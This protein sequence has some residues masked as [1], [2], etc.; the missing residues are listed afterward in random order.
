MALPAPNLD[1]RRFQDLVDDA[2]RL[3]QQHCPEWTDHNVS[4]P[5]VTLIEL[6][7]W[8]TDQLLYRLNRVPERNYLKFL[9]LIGVK[10]FPPS[11]ARADVTFWLSAPRDEPVVVPTGTQIATA[12]S[13]TDEPISFMT[14]QE[15]DIEPCS[16]AYLSTTAAS[17]DLRRHAGRLEAGER[18]AAFDDPPVEGDALL[19]G[20]LQPVPSCAVVLRFDCE[21]EGVGVDPL[22]PP[23]AWEAW[24]GEGWSECDL[25]RDETGGLNRAGDVVLHVPRTHAASLI[26]DQRAGWLRCR[27]TPGEESQP[28]YTASPQISALTAFTLGGTVTAQNAEPIEGEILGISDGTPGQRFAL[29]RGPVVGGDPLVLEVAEAPEYHENGASGLGSAWSEW[30]PTDTFARG[31]AD[32]RHFVLDPIAGEVVLAPAVRLEDGSLKRYGAVPPKGAVLRLRSYRTGGGRRGN[33][34]AGMLKVLKSSL[35][36]VSR[37]ENRYPARGGVDGEDVENAKLRAP[38]VLRAGNRA[39]TAEDYEHLAREAAPEVA[40]VRCVPA[41]DDIAARAVRVLVVPAAAHEHG[42]VRFE[43]LVPT[44]EILEKVARHLDQRRVIGARVV[45]E[46][47]VY[48]GITVVARL[49]PRGRADPVRLQSAALDALYHHFSPITGGPDGTGWPFGRPALVGEVHSVL[50]ALAGAEIVEEARLYAAD[51]TTGER[52]KAVDRIE[53]SPNALVFSFEHRVRVEERRL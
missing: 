10:L 42:K 2:K 1:D 46:P 12:R 40:R 3:V 19:V 33:L 49:R 21:I 30:D 48:Q 23:L 26:G 38:I 11:A 50:Q 52:G 16:L 32:A 31:D 53:L 27:V 37:V 43:D 7:A 45:V 6:F 39:V 25:E 8:M 20:L 13:A 51:P 14:T 5:G 17:G 34:A 9:D 15:L 29:A 4:D 44:E 35:P 22:N 36:Y 18:V 47:P 24:D 41:G 28:A